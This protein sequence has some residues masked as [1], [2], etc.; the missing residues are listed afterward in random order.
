MRR[1][2][3]LALWITLGALSAPPPSPAQSTGSLRGRVTTDRGAP[4][5]GAQVTLSGTNLGTLTS[6]QGQFLLV[7]VPAGTYRLQVRQIGYETGQATVQV[8]AGASAVH[9]FSLAEEAVALQ[10]V[11][12]SVGSRAAHTAADELAVPVDVFPETELAAT[13]RVEMTEVLQELSPAI[14]FP[15]PQISD[16]TSGVRPFQLRGLSPDHALV[17]IN[18]KRRHPTAVV[19]VFGG[20]SMTSGSS[21]VDMNAIPSLALGQMEILRDGAAA[22][23]GSDAIAGVINMNLKNTVSASTVSASYGFYEPGEPAFSRDGQR[24]D[25]AGNVGVPILGRGTLNFTAQASDRNK[26]DRACPD[27]RDQITT[28]DADVVENCQVV[29]KRNSIPQPNHLDGDGE[30]RNYMLFWNAELPLTEEAAQRQAYLFGG[31]SRRED[32]HSGFY[33]RSL[34]NRNWPEIF[35]VGFLPTFRATTRDVMAV[36]GLR[37]LMGEWRYDL[38][39][40][41]GQNRLDNDIFRSLNVSLGPC[42]DRPCAP[43]R[44]GILGNADDPGIPNQTDMYA[45]SLELN[46]LVSD[47]GLTRQVEIGLASPL[48]V[49]VGA[50]WRSDN[51]VIT[52]GDSASWVNG[53]HK[54]RRGGTAA[55]GSQVF[56]GYLPKQEVDAWRHNVGFYADFEADV[57]DRFLV[58]TAARFENYTDFGS[59]VTGKLAVRFQPLEQLILRS[60]VSTGFRAPALSQTYYAHTSTG[61]RDDPDNPGNQLAY[62]IGEFPVNSP[63]A[64]ALGAQDLQEEKSRNFSAGFAFTP[65]SGFNVTADYYFIRV[66]D[67]IMLSN[68][69]EVDEDTEGGR[70]IAA[71]LEGYNAQAVKYFLNAFNTETQGVDVTVNYRHLL[72]QDRLLEALLSYNYNTQELIGDVRTPDVI[73]GMGATLF[74]TASRIA[75]EKGRPTDRATGRLRYTHGP[76]GA[77]VAANYYGEVTV[78]ENEFDPYFL[79]EYDAATIVDAEL[80]YEVRRGLEISLGAE[81]LFDI[82]PEEQPTGYNFLGIFRYPGSS[83]FGYNGRYLF[84]RLRVTF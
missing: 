17:L 23:Y 59:T 34:D 48:N 84:T 54:H 52:A 36:A 49:A 61:F 68:S 10:E 39:G 27:P 72:G 53:F 38:S 58:A 25:I 16:I 55:V 32:V 12:V 26:T 76:A 71:L 81:N 1:F 41:F 37:G 6:N 29:Q 5:G 63:E 66:D 33:R 31:V 65:F 3:V 42:L 15:R 28:G 40:Q 7:N 4:L 44:D 50:T 82:Y 47:F 69:L 60:A 75:I 8:A 35:P 19:H 13:N 64:R 67:R 56:Q 78:L 83:G 70:R 80:S 9:D 30:F 46:Q 43:G 14:N 79:N 21:G 22:Q 24:W 62:E 20:A 45:G 51:Y 18:G 11:V 73:A 57:T 74:P 77:Q 2:G